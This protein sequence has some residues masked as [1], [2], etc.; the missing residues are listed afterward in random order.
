MCQLCRA[1]NLGKAGWHLFLEKGMIYMIIRRAKIDDVHEAAELICMAWYE[2]AH[3]PM[4]GTNKI[5]VRQVIE[6][7]YKQPK[8]MLS[9]QYVDVAEDKNGIVGLIL[10]YPWEFVPRLCKPIIEEMP[11]VY[12]TSQEDFNNKVIPMVKS[13]DKRFGEYYVDSIAVYPEYRRR[14]I[15]GELLKVAK[16][17][18]LTYGF[19]KIFLT[20]KLGNKKAVSLYK[21]RGYNVKK[22]ISSAGFE[23]LSALKLIDSKKLLA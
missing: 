23:Y 19:D 9:Y 10:S 15:A 7:F 8:N 18:S 22:S 4:D 6:N 5:E 20:V 12:K 1:L 21:K 14:G 11:K 13:K 3:V 16:I 17:K 2:N